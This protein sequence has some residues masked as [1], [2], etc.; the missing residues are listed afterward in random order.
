MIEWVIPHWPAPAGV[1]AYTTTRAG[2]VSAGAYAA[3]NLAAHVGDDPGAVEENRR[4]LRTH[5][6]AEP[7][8]LTQV[9]GNAVARAED[10]AEGVEADAAFTR[11]AGRVCAVLTADCLPVLLCNDV[12]TVVA[13]AHAGWRGLAGGV[14][15]AAVRATNEPS[16]RLL[17]WLGPAIGPQAFEVGAEVRAAFLAHSPGAAA[18]F[19]AKENGKWLADLY[20]LATQRL[21]ALGVER[22][23]GG[24]F[25]TFNETERFYSY[26]RE[27][28]TGRMASLIWLE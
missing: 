16:A 1:R 11:R 6:P 26:R 18:A 27:K 9:H 24:G 7:L 15:E 12:G 22:V 3:L 14:I 4:R 28:A 20:R 19:A 21:N 25:C 5:L 8:W 10:A 17:A 23:F 2:G 13:A